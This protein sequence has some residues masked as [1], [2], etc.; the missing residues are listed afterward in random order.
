MSE[1]GL[2]LWLLQGN[3]RKRGKPDEEGAL[4]VPLRL[5]GVVV[6]AAFVCAGATCD[7]ARGVGCAPRLTQ[8]IHPLNAPHK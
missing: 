1:W 6:N 7:A 8:T 2:E 5:C 3:A 4:L